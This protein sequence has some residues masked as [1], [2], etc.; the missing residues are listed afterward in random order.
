LSVPGYEVR[1]ELGRGSTG[2]AYRARQLS[3]NRV[4]AQK[5]VPAGAHGPG[6][7]RGYQNPGQAA[8]LVRHPQA[9]GLDCDNA[10]GTPHA[11]VSPPMRHKHR[12]TGGAE[13]LTDEVAA[14]IGG[15]RRD[16]PGSE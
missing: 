16:F 13:K 15:H 8:F 12:M 3:L 7:A 6:R 1:G 10:D 4:V 14:A 2:V 9:G 5:C 11:T